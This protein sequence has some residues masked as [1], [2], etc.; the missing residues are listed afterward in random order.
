[1]SAH[2]LHP[3]SHPSA[4]C[5]QLSSSNKAGSA[6]VRPPSSLDSFHYLAQTVR[7]GFRAERE[8][9]ITH[10]A[11]SN[12][13]RKRC[14][15]SG[16]WL[17]HPRPTWAE[18]LLGLTQS[19]PLLKLTASD[20]LSSYFLLLKRL[21]SRPCALSIAL[22]RFGLCY[23]SWVAA[24]SSV[25]S[26]M[27]SPSRPSPTT[28]WLLKPREPGWNRIASPTPT[29]KIRTLVHKRC[30]RESRVAAPY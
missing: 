4:H 27:K 17:V 19:P 14:G 10:I 2:Q 11:I 29:P 1:M 18:A 16:P 26:K 12:T 7:P 21:Y 13:I 30:S 22:A 24:F 28:A 15:C 6:L 9:Y 8:M 20:L 3:G 5:L 23:W 25:S